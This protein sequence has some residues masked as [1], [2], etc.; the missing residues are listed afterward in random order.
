MAQNDFNKAIQRTVRTTN[1]AF[2]RTTDRVGLNTDKDLRV[3][4]TLAPDDF[5]VLAHTFGPDEVMDYIHDMEKK[6]LV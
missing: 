4:E 3:Y 5:D 6:R 1:T 2:Q